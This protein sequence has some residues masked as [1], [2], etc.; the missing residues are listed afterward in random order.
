[1]EL[2]PN[3]TAREGYLAGHDEVRLDGLNRVLDSGVRDIVSARGG[4]GIT[5]LLDRLPWDRLTADGVRFVG[6]SDLTA[7]LNPLATE[8]PQI[9]GPMAAAGMTRRSNSERLLD[10]LRGGLTGEVLFRFP[11][12]SVLRH[13]S[14]SGRSA[15]GNLSLLSSLMGTRWEPDLTDRVLFLEEVSEP[16]YR[17]DRLL[18]HLRGSASFPRVK[19][20]I[21]GTL[22]ACRPR[23]EC[24]RRWSEM[25]LEA[26]A[27]HVPVVIGLPFGHGA[28]NL[29]F[30]IG[31]EVTVDTARGEVS[32]N[33]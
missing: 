33:P 15:G 2:A 10:V 32:W 20:L 18:T 23:D 24:V 21:C 26:T 7:L 4:Y 5:R 29:A 12:K 3:L 6:F 9:H 16:P 19:A 17:L 25:V 27:N 28:S 30:P 22:H 8:V 14:V 31:V 1:L 13:G 11:E